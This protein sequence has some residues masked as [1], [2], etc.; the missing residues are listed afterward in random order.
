LQTT[1]V[2]RIKFARHAD[3]WVSS[4]LLTYV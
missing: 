3:Q 1:E 2:Y 4:N